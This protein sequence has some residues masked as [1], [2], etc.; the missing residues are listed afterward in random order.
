MQAAAIVPG[1]TRVEP[2]PPRLWMRPE[3]MAG[4]QATRP[5]HAR[6]VA[7]PTCPQFQ[8]GSITIVAAAVFDIGMW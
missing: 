3:G 4:R 6:R 2:A 7:W 5:D 1:P 8:A